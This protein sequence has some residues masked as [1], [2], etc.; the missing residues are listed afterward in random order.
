MNIFNA[1]TI[2]TALIEKIK[3]AKHLVMLMHG[4]AG[5]ILPKLYDETFITGAKKYDD[6]N[7]S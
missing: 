6:F 7:H 2:P 5:D 1:P 4:K 3:T